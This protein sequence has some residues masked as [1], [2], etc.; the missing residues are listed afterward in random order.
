MPL[1]M[2]PRSKE[3]IAESTRKSIDYSEAG[4]TSVWSV[5]R[6]WRASQGRGQKKKKKPDDSFMRDT[7]RLD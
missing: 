2:S 5:Q 7:K 4:K 6:I 1:N 3:E